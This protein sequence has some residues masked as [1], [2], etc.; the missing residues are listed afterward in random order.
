MVNIFL[1][2]FDKP[3]DKNVFAQYR[4]LLPH[5]LQKKNSA[6]LLWQDSHAHLFGKLL[7]KEA[8]KI[9]GIKT[10]CWDY[11]IYNSFKRPCL[12]LSK[13]D[14]NISHSGSYVICVIGKGIRVG[15]DIEKIKNLKIET[16]LDVMSSYQWEKINNSQNRISEFYR[17]WTIMESVV[18]ADGQGMALPFKKLRLTNNTVYCNQKL[19]YIKEIEIDSAYKS[20]LATDHLTEFKIHRINYY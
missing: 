3:L 5:Y 17:Y 13:F 8:L 11:L 7:F 19:W 15:I 9:F 2:S 16:F 1:T 18:K 10:N 4:A 14:I 6:Y 20:A 12:T